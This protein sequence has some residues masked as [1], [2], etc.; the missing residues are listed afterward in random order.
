M[1]KFFYMLI[2][3]FITFATASSTLP[4]L[5][6]SQ[7]NKNIGKSI[8]YYEDKSAKMDFEQIKNLPNGA[9][10]PLNKEVDSQLFTTSAFWYKFDVY[11]KDPSPLER[12]IVIGIPWIDIIKIHVENENEQLSVYE[13]GDNFA[14]KN[15]TIDHTY[16]NFEHEFQSGHSSVYVQVKTLDP[17]IVPLSVMESSEFLHEEVSHSNY[18]GFVYGIIMAMLLYNLVLFFNIKI[19][20]YGFYVLYLGLFL[21]MNAS[22]NCYT[23]KWFFYDYPTIQNWFESTT[24]YLF[25]IG[26][27]LFAQSFLNL[28]N[29]FAKLNLVTNYL[30]LFYLFIMIVTFFIGYRYHVAFAIGLSVLF[31][32][33]VFGITI[34]SIIMGSHYA[35]LFLLAITAGLLGTLITALTVMAL[36]P[37]TDAGLHAIDYGMIIDTILLSFA[38]ADRFKATQEEKLMAENETKKALEA[39]KAKE[40]FLSN[41]SHEIR[42]PMNAIIGFLNILKNSVK[43]EKNLSYIDIIQSSSKTMLHL[44]DDIL[45]FSKIENGKL[46]INRHPFNPHNELIHCLKLFEASATEK[47][48]EIFTNVD[49]NLPK[50]L[51]GD[52]IRIKQIMF[53]FLS[54]AI[55]FSSEGKKIFIDIKYE[56]EQLSISVQDEGIGISDEAQRKIFDPFEQADGTTAKKYGGTGLGLSIS[57]KLAKLMGGKTSLSSTLGEG[58]TFTL[59]LPIQICDASDECTLDKDTTYSAE[60]FDY[61]RLSG[62]ILVAED[63]KMNQTLMKILLEEYNLECTIASDGLEAVEMFISS[64]YNLILMDDS[65]PNMTGIEA[66]KKIRTYERKNAL[67]PTPIVALTANVMEDDKMKFFE[68]GADDFIAKPIDILEFNRVLERFLLKKEVPK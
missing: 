59:S 3:F 38:L 54:N 9:F 26:G 46:S 43:G 58:S 8:L 45:D 30:L 61:S 34:Y 50:C 27:I 13:G 39:K 21:L 15:R 36:I 20:Y 57:S 52:L 19:S 14:Y 40:E 47:S 41:M 67:K 28:K 16:T 22:Y 35:R 66:L 1:Q 12:L 18:T 62:H 10:K 6:L 48:I 55:K 42:T 17:F 64:K 44:I 2:F 63:N 5:D 4:V 68:A 56:N 29:S 65:M 33:Y 53:N 24:I 37:Y 32:I 51:E 60:D 25:S 7:K 23:F 11:N 49:K 31:S